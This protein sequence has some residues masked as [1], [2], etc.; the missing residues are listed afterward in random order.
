MAGEKGGPSANPN[1]FAVRTDANRAQVQYYAAALSGLLGIF[2]LFH[3]G[4]VAA[5]K[6]GLASK[7]PAL[8]I[9]FLYVSR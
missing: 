9:P 7:V 8:S 6:S 3:L 5:Q 2:I 4:R 1:A